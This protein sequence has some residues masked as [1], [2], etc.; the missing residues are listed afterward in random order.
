MKK[1][2]MT[3]DDLCR[4]IALEEEEEE[5]EEEEVRQ[6]QP[7]VVDFEFFTRNIFEI[8]FSKT[9]FFAFSRIF[10]QLGSYPFDLAA[11]L[12][13]PALLHLAS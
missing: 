8:L 12:R 13:R 9:Y 6:E 1:L 7:P 11:F 3:I 2:A 10:F 5:E 4:P